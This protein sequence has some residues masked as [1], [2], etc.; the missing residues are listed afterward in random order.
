M[1]RR[2]FLGGALG[3]VGAASIALAAEPSEVVLLASTIGPIDAG[4]VPAL[5]NAFHAR[6]GVVVRFVG[7]GTGATLEMSKRGEFDLVMVHALSLEKKFLAEGFGLDRRDVM[8]NDFVL[9]GPAADPAGIKGMDDPKA[10]LRRIAGAQA[11][12]VTRGDNSGTHVAEK[13]LW[14]K[15][16]ISPQGGWYEV[17]EKG[18][19]GNGPTLRHADERGAYVMMDRA[20]WVVLKAKLSL[21]LLVEGHPDLFNF[22]SIIRINPERFAKANA[23][24]AQRFAD[25][26]VSDEAQGLIAGFG[27]AEY[28]TPLFFANAGPKVRPPG[29]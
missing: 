6:T 18:S 5:A 10:A 17:F 3:T 19:S 7:A 8:Y 27:Q 12:F 20:T 2:A 23:A 28:G 26:L 29:L 16:G 22:I 25:W 11:R 9:L 1:N 13:A 24:G 15:A 14:D 4:I 21:A